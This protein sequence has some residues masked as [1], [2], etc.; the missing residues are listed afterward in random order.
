MPAEAILPAI[1]G[2]AFERIEI[3][4]VEPVLKIARIEIGITV[5]G[6]W[7]RLVGQCRLED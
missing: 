4:E 7:A 6:E 2:L 5:F 3:R 1:L